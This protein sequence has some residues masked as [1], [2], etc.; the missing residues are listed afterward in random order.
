MDMAA[1]IARFD[2][3]RFNGSGYCA[4]LLGR[5]DTAFGAIVALADVDHALDVVPSL[6]GRLHSP[7]SPATSSSASRASTSTR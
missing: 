5:G 6:Q 7:R 4:G 3:E 1:D 2:H